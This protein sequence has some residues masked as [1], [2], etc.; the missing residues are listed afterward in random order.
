VEKYEG[1]EVLPQPEE[2]VV[3]YCREEEVGWLERLFLYF[4]KTVEVKR[5]GVQLGKVNGG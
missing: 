4:L 5:V 1:V 3:L 2:G